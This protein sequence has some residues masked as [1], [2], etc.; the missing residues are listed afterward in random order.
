MEK[1]LFITIEGP[2]GS[3]KSTQVENI[4]KYFEDKGRTVVRTREPGGTPISEKLREILLDPENSEM[5][6]VTEMMI[7]AAA[8][9][10]HVSEKIRPAIEH[11]EI[12]VCDRFMDSSIAYQGYGRGLGSVVRDV[13][14]I[15]VEGLLPDITFFMDIDPAV[16]R[17]RIARNRG[18]EDRLEREAMDFHYRLYDG[19]KAICAAEPER[20]VRI[21]AD[22]S[23][24]EIRNDIYAK[25]DELIEK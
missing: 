4:V 23:V 1:G 16:G 24:E 22:R 5:S 6:A 25:L 18:V 7:Y 12:V 19:F 2:D 14:M 21:D 8:R 20:V 9:A 17:E 15:A 10:Q 11:G 13:N 3:G